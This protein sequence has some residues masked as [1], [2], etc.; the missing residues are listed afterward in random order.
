MRGFVNSAVAAIL[1]TATSPLLAQAE[2]LNNDTVLSLV[3]AGLPDEVIVAKIKSSPVEFK[4]STDDIIALK[5]KGL[6]GPVITAMIERANVLSRPAMSLDAADPAVPHPSGVYVLQNWL[7]EPKMK[8]IDPTAT[9]QA[10][11]GGILGYALTSGIASMSIKAAVQNETSRTAVQARKPVFFMFFDESN[12]DNAVATSSWASGSA[13]TISSPNEL[14]LIGL[15][16]KK[17]RREARVGSMNIA[18]AK[19]GVMDKDRVEFEFEMVRPGVYKIS[20]KSELAPGEYGFIFS[21]T[22]GGGAN[23]AMTARIF[24]FTIG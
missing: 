12:P 13:S 16:K 23:G 14:T 24:D 3:S 20:P 5:A 10:K 8:R 1:L 6:S 7:S 17:G 4:L 21:L 18:G 19:V 22:S 9:S 2:K 15:E 11:T